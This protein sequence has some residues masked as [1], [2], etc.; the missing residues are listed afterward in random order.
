MKKYKGF[1]LIDSLLSFSVVA[2]ITLCL[3][4]MYLNMSR[5][6]EKKKDS[7]ENYRVAYI[8]IVI[9]KRKASI[10]GDYI[11]YEKVEKYCIRSK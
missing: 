3:L 6:Y 1:M 10:E 4:P 2:I 8:E 5:V 9:N 11:C 7:L